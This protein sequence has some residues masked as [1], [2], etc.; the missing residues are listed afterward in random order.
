[1]IRPMT[2][3]D[4]PAVGRIWLEASLL[5]HD[6]VPAEFWRADHE[7]MVSEVLPGS[8]GFVHEGDGEIDGF[9]VL[10][11]GPR[12]H[13]MGALFVS[14]SRQG[15]GIGAQLVDQVKGL[16]DPLE[17]SVYQQNERAFGF[18]KARGFVVTGEAVC[19]HT[20]CKEHVLR[21][22]ATP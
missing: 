3:D 9:V 10:G 17:T 14:P 7:L 15:Q 16:R 19:E 20:G 8:F 2:D 22:T 21:W 5:A 13:V 18:Y 11:S 12:A 1:M 6:F 4:V